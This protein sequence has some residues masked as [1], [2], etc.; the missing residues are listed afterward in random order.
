MGGFEGGLMSDDAAGGVCKSKCIA[1]IIVLRYP[2]R[3]VGLSHPVL[4]WTSPFFDSV[5]NEHFSF[6]TYLF[7]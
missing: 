4:D 5:M 2:A 6:F 7:P 1:A 3:V